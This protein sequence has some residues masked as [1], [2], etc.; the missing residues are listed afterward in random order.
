MHLISSQKGARYPRFFLIQNTSNYFSNERTLA[1]HRSTQ[2]IPPSLPPIILSPIRLCYSKE[3]NLHTS[4][5]SLDFSCSPVPGTGITFHSD[6]L[7]TCLWRASL[8][9]FRNPIRIGLPY[10]FHN[11]TPHKQSGSHEKFSWRSLTTFL[12]YPAPQICS[13]DTSMSNCAAD[14]TKRWNV[15]IRPSNNVATQN[16]ISV[17]AFSKCSFVLRSNVLSTRSPQQC[18]CSKLKPEK[19]V[20]RS[21]NNRFTK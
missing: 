15:S 19:Q 17:I 3:C 5:L 11:G 8:I 6:T 14:N 18:Y 21:P 4:S 13:F 1:R 12:Q 2:S 7:P 10:F 9:L 20:H 16:N